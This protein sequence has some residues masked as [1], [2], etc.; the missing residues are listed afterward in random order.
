MQ[1][2]ECETFTPAFHLALCTLHLALFFVG[3]VMIREIAS[4]ELRWSCPEEWLP[5]E[6]TAKIE[7]S[8]GIIGQDRAVRALE[9]GLSVESLGFNVFAT[10]LVGTGKMTAI[11]LHLRPLADQGTPPH[12]LLYVYNF[13][14]PEQ[15]RLLRLLAGRGAILRDRLDRLHRRAQAEPARDLRE[16]GLPE[17]ARAGLRGSQD[18]SPGDPPRLREAG[19]RGRVHTRPGAGRDDDPAGDPAARRREAG[20]PREA[21]VAGRGGEVRPC[22]PRTPRGAAR[23][24]LRGAAARLPRDDGGARGDARPRRAAPPRRRGTAARSRLHRDRQGG[25]R[26]ARRPVPPGPRQRR[27]RAPRAVRRGGGRRQGRP[28]PVQRQP[29]DR[30][31][32]DQGPPGRDRDRAVVRQPLRHGRGAGRTEL[33]VDLRPHPHPRRLV[34]ARQRRLPRDQ[35]VRR[36][37]RDRCLPGAQARTTLPARGRQAARDSVRPDRAGDPAGAGGPRREGRDGRRPAALRHAPRC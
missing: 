3:V 23:E 33:A 32:R 1:G 12:D 34:A 2:A 5:A 21:A 9:F 27:G 24:A 11:E 26:S 16:R 10:G 6:S 37:D 7:P 31:R 22:P 14:H 35:R 4:Q 17:A 13:G 18:P 20:H 8:Q 15:P 25:R 28:H 29:P 36:P 19:P 30:Q